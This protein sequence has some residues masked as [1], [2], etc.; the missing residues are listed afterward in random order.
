MTEEIKNDEYAGEDEGFVVEE[1]ITTEETVSEDVIDEKTQRDFYIKLRR[2]VKSYVEKHPNSKYINYLVAA[3]DFFHL[4][5]KLVID[6][7]VPIEKKGLVMGAIVY[8]V[9]PIDIISDLI[10]GVGI[11]DDVIIA[12]NVVNSLI[13]SVG[14][15]VIEEHW[16]GD[17][18]VWQLIRK[19]LAFADS[20]VGYRVIEKIKTW[21][22][23]K[24]K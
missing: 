13:S 11:I 6:P 17:E 14:T 10:P 15:E 21:F 18:N 22:D 9:S 1:N 16:A 2:K 20:V 23:S 7:R 19:L 3:P 5:C 4:L 8:F 12:V 24:N